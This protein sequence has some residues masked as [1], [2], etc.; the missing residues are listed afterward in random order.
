MRGRKYT[1][2]WMTGYIKGWLMTEPVLFVKKDGAY[3]ED[4]EDMM[5]RMND[6]MVK[7]RFF[8]NPD[9]TIGQLCM[10]TNTNRAYLSRS[11][12]R[13]FGSNF[14]K[15]VNLFRIEEAKRLMR[16]RPEKKMDL[17]DLAIEC[18]FNSVRSFS[19]VFKAKESCTPKQYL[20]NVKK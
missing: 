18:G 10:E 7:E 4:P 11:I 8:K 20:R 19:R 17:F 5:I 9:L 13:T 15:W 6:L 16:Q 3:P 14:S 12:H 2:K 1:G